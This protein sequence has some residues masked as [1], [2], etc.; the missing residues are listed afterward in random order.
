MF[1]KIKSLFVFIKKINIKSKTTTLQNNTFKN[2]L[3][4][5]STF[6]TKLTVFI[7]LKNKTNNFIYLI[8]SQNITKSIQN[9]LSVEDVK[10]YLD[11]LSK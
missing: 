10:N 5:F 1:K 8:F 2:V 6:L 9:K 4:N 3:Q 7:L 11:K